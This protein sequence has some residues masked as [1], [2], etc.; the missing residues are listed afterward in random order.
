MS[1][2]VLVTRPAA[3]AERTAARLRALGHEP[4]V[5]P[6]LMIEPTNAPPPPGPFGAV[7]VTSANGVPAVSDHARSPG[8]PR[9]IPV[10]AVGART[11]D[12]LGEAGIPPLDW[13]E[14]GAELAR[15]LRKRL[16]RG[17]RL[18]LACGRDRKPEPQASLELAGYE[19]VAWETYAAV[20]VPRL[21]PEVVAALREDRI[22]AALHYSRRSVAVALALAERE[23]VRDA[24]L[25]IEHHALSPDAAQPLADAG[26]SRLHVA[27][28]PDE[29]ALLGS[30]LRAGSPRSEPDAKGRNES[31]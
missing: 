20:A 19:V 8:E 24:L 14:D 21:P 9:P 1:L 17:A 4:I 7:L 5:A 3:Q 22:D 30:L 25:A 6:L 13:A 28:R 12:L 10:F 15:G 11:A 23:G 27:A 29:S 2:R 16:P 26:A 18:L 31:A